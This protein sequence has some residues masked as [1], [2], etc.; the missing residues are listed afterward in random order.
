VTGERTSSPAALDGSP[1]AL[2][3]SPAALGGSPAALYGGAV[4][5]FAL[6][7]VAGSITAAVHAPASPGTLATRAAWDLVLTTAVGAAVGGILAGLRWLFDRTR[8]RGSDL[9]L[10]APHAALSVL[11]VELAIG[12]AIRHQADVVMNGAYAD[13]FEITMLLG[14]GVGIALAHLLGG[15][16]A[17][18]LYA[19]IPWGVVAVASVAVNGSLYRDD[20]AESHAVG[21]WAAASALAGLF[22]TPIGRRLG[23]RPRLGRALG[24]ASL[25]TLLSVIVQPSNA[26]RLE[27]FRSASTIGAW[28]HASTVWRKPSLRAAGPLPVAAAWLD[29]RGD[30]API[31]P[32]FRRPVDG[33]PVVV[34][35]T[36]DAV[37]AD[38]SARDENDARWPNLARLKR[39]GAY[40]TR[41]RA[42]GSQTAVSLSALFSGRYFSELCW[43]KHGRG[44]MRFDY[45]ADD[46]TPR[47]PAILSAHGVST[48]KVGSVIFL[49]NEY[50]VASGFSEENMLVDNRRHA[51]ANEVVEPIVAKL[52]KVGSGPAFVFG[53]LMEPHAP[54]DRGAVTEGTPLERYESEI[55]VADEALGRIMRAASTPELLPR[56]LL[57]VSSDHGEAFGE[58]GTHEH[59][60]SLYEELVRVP[61]LV[62]GPHVV[63]RRIDAPVTLVDLGPTILDTFGVDTP[64][65]LMGESLVP[66][67]TGLEAELERPIVA[68]GRLRRA[69]VV[70]DLKVIEDLRRKTIEAYDLAADPGELRSFADSDPSR[71]A[72]LVTALDRLF[73]ANRCPWPGYEPVYKP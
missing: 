72:P 4:A 60:K 24:I 28:A 56:V 41:A 42:A 5:G 71:A 21:A 11:V 27:L 35:I 23:A 50:G 48:T 63:P 20:F 64:P 22:A 43:S 47:V 44:G 52:R 26:A 33:A 2:G 68:E 45:P 1:A 18:R 58:H 25:A 15:L 29:R 49:A 46:P 53:H 66:A 70:G 19:A 9:A 37:R 32:S 31:P 13:A 17:K 54:Y 3:G 69:I 34:L 7:S 57:I 39:E 30:L 55:S 12:A 61:L 6:A 38:L 65:E 14:T 73:D 40:F 67:L 59:T 16:A 36:I 8:L 62:K 51:Y 10:L